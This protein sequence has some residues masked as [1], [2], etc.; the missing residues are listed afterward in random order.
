MG[1]VAPFWL[2]REG[3]VKS[4]KV[5]NLGQVRDL[6]A[7][8]DKVKAHI[9][10]GEV[11]GFH[12]SFRDSEQNETTFAGGVYL[13]PVEAARVAL[14]LSAYR[15]LTEDIPPPRMSRVT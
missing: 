9:L 10:N 3:A 6:L 14:R 13:D 5:V 4:H 11:A 1:G 15:T 8:W 2:N 7:E 12:A